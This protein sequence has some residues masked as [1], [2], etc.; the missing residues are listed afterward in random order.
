MFENIPASKS[1]LIPDYPV[2]SFTNLAKCAND[3]FNTRKMSSEIISYRI[4]TIF[5]DIVNSSFSTGLFPDSEKYV[6]VK[7]LLKSDKDRDKLSLYKP[8]YNT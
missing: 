8:L 1:K 7:P 4:T 2:L 3:R 5:T 6:V